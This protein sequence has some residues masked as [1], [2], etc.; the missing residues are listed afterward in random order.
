MKKEMKVAL[1]VD[2]DSNIYFGSTELG[3]YVSKQECDWS[4]PVPEDEE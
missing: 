1:I 4:A 3:S 2:E